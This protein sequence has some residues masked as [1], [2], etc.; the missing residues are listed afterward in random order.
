V[1]VSV[2]VLAG[3]GGGAILAVLPLV[4]P[5]AGQWADTSFNESISFLTPSNDE[6]VLA[7]ALDVTA[8]VTSATG[9]CGDTNGNGVDV[10]GRLE[11]GRLSMRLANASSD[12]LEGEFVTLIRFDAEPLGSAPGHSYF[13]SRVDVNLPAG[14]WVTESGN[15]K[16]KFEQ[17]FSVDNDSTVNVVGCDVSSASVVGFKGTMQGFNTTSGT[18]PT[19]AEW[20]AD[21][22]NALLFQQVEFVDGATLTLTTGGGQRVTLRRQAD[23]ANT[24]CS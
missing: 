23:T 14:L 10:Q 17:P 13:N 20:R 2:I 5:L 4:T 24:A 22:S 21:G 7:S 11:D 6:Q 8:V 3:C 18:R 15:L 1:A 16:L 12:C 19:S 9:V